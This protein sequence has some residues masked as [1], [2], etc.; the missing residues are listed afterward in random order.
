MSGELISFD[1]IVPGATVRVA[2]IDGVQYLSIRD[3]IMCVCGKDGNQA[4]EVW[5]RMSETR[6]SELFPFLSYYQFPGQ[7]QSE[8]PVITLP[9]S[10]KM[11]MVLPG[12]RPKLCRMI[13][14]NII[15]RY[16]DGDVTM[17]DE[18]K[19]NRSIGKKRSYSKFAQQMEEVVNQVEENEIPQVQYIYA[20]KCPAFP[21]LIKIGKTANMKA[22][23]S[24]LNTACAPAPHT[25]V[26]MAPTLDM[27]RDEC[28]AH[29]WFA[30]NRRQGEFFDI[31][32]ERVKEYFFNTI[33]A[34]YQ[35]E[36]IESIQDRWRSEG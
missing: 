3:V 31:S 10:I 32:E 4:N 23:L 17:C 35:K 22:R 14:A 13:F 11:V 36:L 24:Q 19:H 26:T 6:K 5:R 9:D 16:L 20:T 2:V 25:V 12:D 28:L 29:R 8:Q 33:T 18:I 30:N 7:G 15:S 34:R 21:G 1:E 27:H